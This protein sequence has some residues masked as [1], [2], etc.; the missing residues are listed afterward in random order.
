MSMHREAPVELQRATVVVLQG[1]AEKQA[2]VL[3]VP[4]VHTLKFEVA[5]VI[6]DVRIIIVRCVF[7]NAQPGFQPE[8]EVTSL[9]NEV[10][11][12]PVPAARQVAALTVGLMH[13]T[14]L[15]QSVGQAEQFP[16][17]SV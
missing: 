5:K 14:R 4:V 12:Y 9:E 7:L 10:G 13:N 17:R 2:D 1:V 16:L 8:I 3:L 15:N 11:V 6:L